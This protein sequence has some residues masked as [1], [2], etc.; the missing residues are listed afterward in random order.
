MTN[1]RVVGK[2]SRWPMA[3]EG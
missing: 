3:A 1:G 2:G